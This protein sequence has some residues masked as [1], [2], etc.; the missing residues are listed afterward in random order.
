MQLHFQVVEEQSSPG[1]NK[2]VGIVPESGILF[3]RKHFLNNSK[4]IERLVVSASSQLSAKES[5]QMATIYLEIGKEILNDDNKNILNR[6][7]LTT[8]IN[9]LTVY[10][11]ALL[12]LFLILLIVL[13]GRVILFRK[14]SSAKNSLSKQVYSITGNNKK[15]NN[16]A[17]M[18]P[19]D[20]LSPTFDRLRL[21][22]PPPL[23]CNKDYEKVLNNSTFK[24]VYYNLIIYF[25]IY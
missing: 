12:L 4:N 25:L 1:I 13:I 10:L 24:K 22:P 9:H 6:F 5:K 14:T 20:R 7:N 11:M 21:P 3:L 15:I 23:L 2:Y 18:A 19:I 8:K 16:L 17:P